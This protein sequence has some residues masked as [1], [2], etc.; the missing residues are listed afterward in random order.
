MDTSFLKEVAQ[1][2]GSSKIEKELLYLEGKREDCP[3]VLPF[4][5]EFSSGK[6][7]LI[8]AL[9][10]CKQLE[11]ATTPTTATIYEVHFGCE[12]CFA[13]VVFPDNKRN[14]FDSISELHNE[15]I[16][17]ASVVEVYDTSNLVSSSIVLV[18]TPGLSSSDPRHKQTLIEF[19]PE[20][21]GILLVSDINQPGLTR[22]LTD[23]IK[24]M[25]LSKRRIYLILTKCDTKSEKE[26]NEAK[27]YI[28]ANNRIKQDYIV[29]VSAKDNNVTELLNLLKD[30]QKDKAEIMEQVNKQRV[31]N[32]AQQLDNTI[33]TLK[34]S[35]LSDDELDDVI[36]EQQHRLRK[37]NSS[38]QKMMDSL[39]DEIR[40]IS[41]KAERTYEDTVFARLDSIVGN[42]GINY[43][44]EALSVINNSASLVISNMRTDIRNCVQKH[45]KDSSSEVNFSSL[46][47]VDLDSFSVDGFAYN[48]NL[49]SLGHEYDG[50]IAKGLK[51]A[52]AVAAVC[53]AA[54]AIAGAGTVGAAGAAEA[55]AGSSIAEY[56]VAD[57]VIDAT[58]TA[59]I[60]KGGGVIEPS[61]SSASI[62]SSRREQILQKYDE[63]EQQNMEIAQR[64][65]MN[66]GVVESVVGL[67]TDSTMGKPQRRRAI[68]EYMDSTLMPSFRAAVERNCNLLLSTIHKSLVDDST[69]AI[70]EL[71]DSLSKLKE[72]KRS[73]ED[74]FAAKI[75]Q[76]NNYSTILKNEYICG[77]F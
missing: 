57:L 48:L 3:I 25:E 58:Q 54:P 51:I 75:K 60:M 44:V 20:A 24:T 61:Q 21:D 23:F 45:A 30:I 33:A 29:S 43:D 15:D 28:A 73:K 50:H 53:V 32:I 69:V 12:K 68:Q 4:M 40:E 22:S 7:S 76:L 8:N 16:V 35:T 6:T 14:H 36:E 17:D 56:G 42:K 72:E 1:F 65:G 10:D 9:T 13:E 74:D 64:M 2:I 37:L 66:G 77:N 62:N 18:D 59:A 38:I 31:I 49:N 41:R 34:K 11:T 19:L 27:K 47:N 63:Y 67:V 71:K 70:S 5:G 46:D 52:A 39:S 26:I 55:A